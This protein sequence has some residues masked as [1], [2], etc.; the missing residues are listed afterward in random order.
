[1]PGPTFTPGGYHSFE[2]RFALAE[3]FER[4]TQLG[5]TRVAERIRSLATRLKQGLAELPRVLLITPMP[6]RLS[7]GIERHVR[8]GTGL[9]VDEADVDAAP[10]AIARL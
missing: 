7:A 1:M 3:A 9:W 5:R 8:F 2:H 10:A 4:Q 6:E